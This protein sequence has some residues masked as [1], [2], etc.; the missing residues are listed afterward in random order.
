MVR[1]N[2]WY[3]FKFLKFTK[4]HFVAQHMINLG[5]CFMCTW[6]CILLLLDRMLYKYQLSPFCLMCHVRPVLPYLFIG[7]TGSS[8]LCRLF[9]SCGKWGLLSYC[10]EQVSHCVVEHMTTVVV[11]QWPSSWG[12]WALVHRFSS[13]GTSAQLLCIWDPPIP[14]IEL[15]SPALVVDSPPLNHWGSPVLLIFCLDNLS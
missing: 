7:C 8:L 13:C 5:E 6:I 10:S 15:M 3:Y 12:S 11:A 4:A 14:R 2:G 1:K 9:S